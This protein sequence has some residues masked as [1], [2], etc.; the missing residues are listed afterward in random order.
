MSQRLLTGNIQEI[1]SL[2]AEEGTAR[3]R[4]KQPFDL[5]ALPCLQALE[6]GTER[7]EWQ[8]CIAGFVFFELGKWEK[9]VDHYRMVTMKS[10]ELHSKLLLKTG[11]SIQDIQ[12]LRDMI[13]YRQWT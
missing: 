8:E 4:Q 5:L 9:A 2:L 3:C 10:F 13:L 6:N 12:L 1:F 11:H 7:T